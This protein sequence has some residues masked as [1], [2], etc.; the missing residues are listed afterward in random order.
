[1][2][3]IGRRARSSAINAATSSPQRSIRIASSIMP[4]RVPSVAI[5]ISLS[6]IAIV[7]HPAREASAD[8]KRTCAGSLSMS[9]NMRVPFGAKAVPNSVPIKD[10]PY[11]PTVKFRLI[12][13]RDVQLSK[14]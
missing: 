13:I 1:M 2:G 5:A 11:P 14:C 6:L 12:A 3:S 7:R 4:S 8:T 9:I 10:I